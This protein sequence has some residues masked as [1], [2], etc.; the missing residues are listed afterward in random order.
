MNLFLI[1]MGIMAV[2]LAGSVVANTFQYDAI[3]EVNASLATEKANN[4]SLEGLIG[5]QNQTIVLLET[6]R[7]TDQVNLD[8]LTNKYSSTILEKEKQIA[9]LNSFRDRLNKA[10]LDRPA[11]VGRLATRSVKRLLR[12]F[13]TASGGEEDRAGDSVSPSA[14]DTNLPPGTDNNGD[15]ART[16][17]TV[18]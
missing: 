6:R 10:A 7:A 8:D 18:E 1:S 12:N 14:A 5:E 3:Q 16:D 9:K 4:A 13:Y 15:N 11:L 2:L 17:Q